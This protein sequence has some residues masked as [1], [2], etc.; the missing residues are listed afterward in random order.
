MDEEEERGKA[1]TDHSHAS[2]PCAAITIQPYSHR[3]PEKSAQVENGECQDNRL[4]QMRWLKKAV[5]RHV[6][7]LLQG[8]LR[9][10]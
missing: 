1:Q 6:L 7:S 3:Q 2:N 8:I 5:E 9:F 10:Y 4:Y